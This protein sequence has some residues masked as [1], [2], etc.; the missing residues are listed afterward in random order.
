MQ[1]GPASLS[2][3]Y[4]TERNISCSYKNELLSTPQPEVASAS[5]LQLGGDYAQVDRAR[6]ETFY[7]LG[8]PRI[9]ER[10]TRLIFSVSSSVPSEYMQLR[11]TDV[12]LTLDDSIVM[13]LKDRIGSLPAT[14]A[15][16]GGTPFTI[17]VCT[18]M[19][20]R[21]FCGRPLVFAVYLPSLDIEINI[22][23]AVPYQTHLAPSSNQ[24]HQLTL[25]PPNSPSSNRSFS[26][27]LNNRIERRGSVSFPLSHLTFYANF[28][29][30]FYVHLQTVDILT[31][32]SQIGH[33]VPT[34]CLRQ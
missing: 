17:R 5:Q 3:M 21:L 6:D 12:M 20:C 19:D 13:Y 34:K 4:S 18:K 25:S 23:S 22:S 15:R 9:T 29:S 30:A 32:G 11:A 7:E 24:S 31:F 26:L 14:F 8:F 2:K 16:T 28:A 27:I 33:F 10:I 1:S